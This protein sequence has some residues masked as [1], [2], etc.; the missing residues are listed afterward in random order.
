MR[1]ENFFLD[2]GVVLGPIVIVCLIAWYV[3]RLHGEMVRAA[4]TAPP[5][6]TVLSLSG[7]GPDAVFV[8]ALRSCTSAE[9][10]WRPTEPA[11]IEV[12]DV[13]YGVVLGCTF[14]K[15]SNALRAN[16]IVSEWDDYQ[17]HPPD[18]VYKTTGSYPLYW[19]RVVKGGCPPWRSQFQCQD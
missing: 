8:S 10:C 6:C 16:L 15:A 13:R 12:I 14:W 19:T 17:S 4:S 18:V 3:Q 9:D 1:T 7:L 5:S 2:F 11:E